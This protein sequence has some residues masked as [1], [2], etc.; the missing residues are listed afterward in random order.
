MTELMILK[1]LDIGFTVAQVG[2]ERQAVLDA[3]NARLQAG[4]TPEQVAAFL[5]K[6][7]DEALAKAEEAVK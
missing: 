7:R 3:A 6:M 2:L 5:V 4:D 1:L